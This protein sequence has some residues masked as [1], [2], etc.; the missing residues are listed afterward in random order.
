MINVY[1]VSGFLGAGK[2]SLIQQMI[3]GMKDVMLLENEFGEVSVD[4]AFFKEGLQVKE[5]NN[6]CICCSLQGDFEKALTEIRSYGIS[7]LIIEPSGV[8]KLSDI[9]PIVLREEDMRLVCHACVV[10]V[11]TAKKYHK[12]FKA[13]FDDQILMANAIVLS[14]LDVAD[15][16]T[17]NEAIEIV[18]TLNDEAEMNTRP[19]SEYSHAELLDFL[20]KN[21]IRCYSCADF[22]TED[23]HCFTNHE[24]HHHHEKGCGCHECQHDHHHHQ[25]ECCS[26]EHP[27]DHHHHDDP[28]ESIAF[29]PSHVFTKEE[30][31]SALSQLDENIIRCK[32][33]VR[34]ETGSYLF[35]YVLNE[36]NI[37]ESGNREKGLVVVIGTEL[38][39]EALKKVFDRHD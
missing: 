11:K 1:V 27:C 14:H 15:A 10:D 18:T 16:Q 30:V 37:M 29:Y 31:E 13:Y 39:M 23:C 5:I 9:L 2:T 32:G 38:P 25:E 36:A 12:N 6:G 21:V 7:N 24:H 22:S 26:K 20:V 34:S 4:S 33:Y 3:S 28:F 35:N 17:V 8:G 19:I